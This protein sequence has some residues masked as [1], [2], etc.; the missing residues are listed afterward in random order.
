MQAQYRESAPYGTMP[1]MGLP[2]LTAGSDDKS[3]IRKPPSK[4]VEHQTETS[5]SNGPSDEGNDTTRL[6]SDYNSGYASG[7]RGGQMP[8][9]SSYQSDRKPS[10]QD[11][12]S[13]SWEQR[14][15]DVGS[16]GV[17]CC[18]CIMCAR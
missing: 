4:L 14:Q 1:A 16:K 6:E 2:I 9:P 3:H 15:A 11:T 7:L 10:Y 17:G 8:A 12:S 18:A 5:S 13:K